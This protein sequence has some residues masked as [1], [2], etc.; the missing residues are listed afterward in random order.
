MRIALIETLKDS[1]PRKSKKG[2]TDRQVKNLEA[3]KKAKKEFETKRNMLIKDMSPKDIKRGERAVA[4]RFLLGASR[5]IYDVAD[6]N[7]ANKQ[8][9]RERNR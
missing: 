4:T 8:L 2:L 3:S 1:K 7:R 5:S 9:E 6:L